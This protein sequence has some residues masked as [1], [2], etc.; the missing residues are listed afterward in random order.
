MGTLIIAGN[1]P[2]SGK[3]SLACA[4]ALLAHRQGRSVRL[5]RP[6]RTGADPEADARFYREVLPDQPEPRDW[7]LALEGEAPSPKA[8]D[9]AVSIARRLAEGADLLVVEGPDGPSEAT[10]RLAEG[11]EGRVL[12]LARFRP[13][14]RAEDLLPLARAFGDRLGGLLLN[15]VLPHRTLYARRELLPALEAQGVRV[16][17][18]VPE[19]RRMLA[20]TVR[21]VAECVDGDLLDF[22]EPERAEALVEA[23]MVGGWFLDH[24]AYVFSRRARKAVLVRADRPDLQMASLETDTVCLVLTGGKAPVQYALVEAEE[25]GVPVI[26][27]PLSTLEAMERLEALTGRATARHPEKPPRFLDLLTPSA[28]LEGLLGGM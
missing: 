9:R 17:G 10:L 24:G 5:F 28:N 1:A 13:G 25:R 7:P 22:G 26:L 4:L 16:L 23:V 14:L 11:L 8:V 27:T 15:R 2:G 3:T 12:A 6:F 19:D 18:M 20:P 21:Q